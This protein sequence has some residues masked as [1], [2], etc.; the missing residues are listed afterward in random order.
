[1]TALQ[2]ASSKRRRVPTPRFLRVK[3]HPLDAVAPFVAGRE[4]P[5]A[6]VCEVGWVNGLTA[7]RCLGRAGVPVI[8]LDHRSWALGFRSRYCLPVLAPDPLTDERGFVSFLVDLADVL[9][10][11]APIFPTHDEHLNTLARH[12]PELGERF[13]YPFPGW[14]VLQPLQSK[15]YQLETAER[16]GLATPATFHPR[17]LE[18]ARGAVEQ[19]GYPVLVKPSENVVFKRL[20]R[21]QAFYC[22]GSDELERAYRLTADYEPMLQ[23]F[24][25]GGDEYLWTLGAYIAADREVLARFCGRK[26]RQ[27]RENMGSARVG[28]ALWDDEVV[29]SGIALLRAL[30][31]H[32]I[33]QV[34]WK[35]D[36]RN[37]QLKLI[38]VNP[39]LWQWHSLSGAC[40]ADVIGSAYRDLVGRRSGP[41]RSDASGKRW[42][43]SIMHG[44]GFALQKPPYVDP[45]FAF[46]DPK[47][48][49]VH[50][51]RFTLAAL[52]RE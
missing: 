13:L 35:R 47:P 5:P 16:L 7:I 9:G 34:E 4:L 37:G 49:A 15:R 43:I 33:A 19:V 48:G 31:F 45:V 10:V 36:P 41:A 52:G 22:T 6:V 11:P 29:D 46:D 17:S 30:G 18:D 21:R 39:R 12:K 14:D 3:P 44:Q 20:H 24:V 25:P 1:M 8:A 23:E 51:A 27:T 42:A 28:E 38:E 2:D 40:G 32:G 26:L 50:A